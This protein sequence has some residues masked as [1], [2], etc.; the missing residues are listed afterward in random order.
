TWLHQSLL[1]WMRSVLT[2]CVT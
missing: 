1:R 2:L